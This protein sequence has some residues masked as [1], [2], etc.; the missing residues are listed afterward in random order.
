MRRSADDRLLERAVF[1]HGTCV[2][3]DEID[4][5]TEWT[6]EFAAISVQE[7]TLSIDVFPPVGIRI[8]PPVNIDRVVVNG[9]THVAGAGATVNVMKHDVPALDMQRNQTDRCRHVRH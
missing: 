4:V 3:S 8:R 7:R 2:S 9:R 6:V 5:T 1:L